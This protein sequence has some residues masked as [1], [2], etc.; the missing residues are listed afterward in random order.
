MPDAEPAAHFA[1][2]VCPST[3]NLYVTRRHGIGRARSPTYRA[4]IER[5]GWTV[6]LARPARVA[7][8]VRVLIEVPF[9]RRRDIDNI[10]KPVL[11]LLVNLDLID[12]DNMVDDLRIIRR[13]GGGSIM[14][15]I[16]PMT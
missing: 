6:K 12:D 7:G 13:I 4:W 11:D 3:N 14:V 2:P 15:S 10:I 5:A 16:W 1:M 9:N 8:A